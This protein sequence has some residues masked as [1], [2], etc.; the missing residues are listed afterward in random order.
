LR[1]DFEGALAAD[2]FFESEPARTVALAW[3]RTLLGKKDFIALGKIIMQTL[4]VTLSKPR[5]AKSKLTS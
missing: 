2:R 1:G 4:G 3:R 5:S